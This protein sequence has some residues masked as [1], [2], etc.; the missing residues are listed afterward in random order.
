MEVIT[1]KMFSENPVYQSYVI[2]FDAGQL[3]P[4]GYD[5]R[6]GGICY[7]LTTGRRYDLDKGEMLEIY[8]GDFISVNTL[9]RIRLPRRC[10]GVIY[11]KWSRSRQGISAFGAKVDPG[12]TGHLSLTFTNEG[13][14]VIKVSK[15]DT[16]C[17][18]ELTLISDPGIDYQP[19]SWSEP[20]MW[21]KLSTKVFLSHTL[22]ESDE[23]ELRSYF[24]RE[25][26]EFYRAWLLVID[27]QNKDIERVVQRAD[28]M[29]YWTIG[30]IAT[31]VIAVVGILITFIIAG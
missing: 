3:T 8:H 22:S 27:K 23:K 10:K 26:L 14:E 20:A 2:P 4:V 18:L 31:M 9:E 15:G 6:A 16:F 5:L 30:L 25:A 12:Y 13:N 28:S 1:A 19:T 11:S 29:Y 24:T 21:S 7:N 17:N